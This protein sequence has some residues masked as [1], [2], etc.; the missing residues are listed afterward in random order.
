MERRQLS[1]QR[2][3]LLSVEVAQ[4]LDG[5]PLDVEGAQAGQVD[6]AVRPDREGAAQLGDIEQLDLEAVAGSEDVAVVG[7]AESIR[8]KLH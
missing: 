5:E 3:E 8:V 2:G 7:D 1:W 6:R 4:L